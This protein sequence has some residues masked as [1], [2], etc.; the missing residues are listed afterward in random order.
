KFEDAEDPTAIDFPRIGLDINLDEPL[1]PTA[2]LAEIG[3]TDPT[4]EWHH[5][6]MVDFDLPEV[7]LPPAPKLP[8]A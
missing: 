7:D 8:R 2:E 1:P 3:S 4:G 5:S 6:N